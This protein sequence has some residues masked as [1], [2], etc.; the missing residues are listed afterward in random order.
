MSQD[1]R[2]ALVGSR[3]TF[4]FSFA[5]QRT[6]SKKVCGGVDERVEEQRLTESAQGKRK[7]S[8]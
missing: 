5:V 2:A 7:F 3:Q 1:A 8:V 4:L 6:T